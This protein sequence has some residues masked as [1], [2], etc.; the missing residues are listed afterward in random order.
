MEVGRKTRPG[1]LKIFEQDCVFNGHTSVAQP[2]PTPRA[3]K[4]TKRGAKYTQMPSKTDR[5]KS[6]RK[7]SKTT[8]EH[9]LWSLAAFKEKIAI[10]RSRRENTNLTSLACNI[11][12]AAV[13]RSRFFQIF[14]PSSLPILALCGILRL[15]RLD[16][17][18]PRLLDLRHPVIAFN[19]PQSRTQRI[20]TP[21]TCPSPSDIYIGSR[22]PLHVY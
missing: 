10:L 7:S 16:L 12:R 5:M 22:W 11:Y 9:S 8:S 4:G 3:D 13:P 21:H 1:N 20:R 14:R 19:Q 15:L 18:A 6:N 17:R 2:H